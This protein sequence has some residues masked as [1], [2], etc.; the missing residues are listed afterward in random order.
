MPRSKPSQAAHAASATE[1]T[2]AMSDP[3]FTMTPEE[4][5]TAIAAIP[6]K[7]FRSREDLQ[8]EKAKCIHF[9]PV[10]RSHPLPASFAV[11]ALALDHSELLEDMVSNGLYAAMSEVLATTV[12][13]G[14]IG[15]LLHVLCRLVKDSQDALL[16]LADVNCGVAEACGAALTTACKSPAAA[17]APSKPEGNSG[18]GDTEQEADDPFFQGAE[19]LEELWGRLPD[20]EE[21]T[22]AYWAQ[23][24]APALAAC[25]ALEDNEAASAFITPALMLLT[26]EE[27]ETGPYHA[28][29][30]PGICRCVLRGLRV[31]VAD[32]LESHT[33]A[34]N[35]HK[36]AR[37]AQGARQLIE[38]GVGPLLPAY[39]S[40][41]RPE[42]MMESC[43][44]LGKLVMLGGPAHALKLLTLP[45][46]QP[47][48]TTTLAPLLVAMLAKPYEA[49]TAAP[50]RGGF[51]DDS[52]W[53]WDAHVHLAIS[54]AHSLPAA[55]SPGDSDSAQLAGA[56]VEAGALEALVQILERAEP[57]R[58]GFG[59][60]LSLLLRNTLAALQM[61]SLHYSSRSAE[62]AAVCKQRV[63][64]AGLAHALQV[65]RGRQECAAGYDGESKQDGFAAG[66]FPYAR[67]KG[68]G[69]EPR[70]AATLQALLTQL[71]QQLLQ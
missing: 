27:E 64:A 33:W 2:D 63:Q 25:L 18:G 66:M 11:L 19:F 52:L 54:L 12:H 8:A 38:G 44:L 21:A 6:E 47:T 31:E 49:K 56:L 17:S 13:P 61:L 16:A 4:Q 30:L 43:A 46:P 53:Y 57:A 3:F 34:S 29:L 37:T 35:A 22:Q 67:S 58:G 41:K 28:L 32:E 26:T 40:S 45:L 36:H 7:S 20:A 65:C 48:T 69:R 71:E 62:A 5:C 51:D 9:L 70:D 23:H 68:E 50:T 24:S 55:A 10:L 15:N 59:R 14:V 42:T 39:I 1:N 60:P